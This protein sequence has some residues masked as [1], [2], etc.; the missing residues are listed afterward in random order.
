MTGRSALIGHTGFVGQNFAA[1][2][3]FDDLYNTSNIA[4]IE[5]RGYE[6]VVCAAN[7]ADSYRINQ[8][9]EQDLAEVRALAELLGRVRIAKLV[10]VSTVCVYPGETTPDETTP[11][12]PEGLTP[13]GQNRLW[14]EQELSRRVD[15]LVL[16]L[17]Q[18]YGQGIK[19]GVVHD[20]IADHRV[21]YINAADRMQHY[22]LGR[23][24]SDTSSALE[25]GL[26]ALNLATP[27]IEN[28]RL[29]AEVFGRR[30]R[31]TPV[32]PPSPFATMYSRDMRTVHAEQLGGTA[33]YLCTEEEELD[34]L[35]RFVTSRRDVHA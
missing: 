35:R 10:I 4:D 31:P 22:D 21:D 23:I 9:Q 34:S 29:A 18:L 8:Q 11:L 7:R 30:L 15:T 24:W 20:L 25:L 16:R 14:F 33:P 17:P 12:S 13:Y 1:H 6:L 26:P 2:H 5:G 28:A 32:E 3:S 19:K 27:P